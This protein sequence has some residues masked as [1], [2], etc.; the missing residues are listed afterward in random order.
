MK[1]SE[2]KILLQEAGFTSTEID[3]WQKDKVKK[4]NEGGFTN[5]EIAEEFG[6]VSDDKP[7]IK[8]WQDVSKQYYEDLYNNNEI[9]SPDD[10]MLYYS[11]QEEGNSK[12]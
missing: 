8:Y 2:Q 5:T 11:L 10:E 4:L 3:N 1:L 9:V 7:F 12:S 6:T